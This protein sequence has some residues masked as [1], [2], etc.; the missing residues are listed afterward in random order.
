[1]HFSWYCL[2]HTCSRTHALTLKCTVCVC[3]CVRKHLKALRRCSHCSTHVS[4]PLTCH[5]LQSMKCEIKIHLW[6]DSGMHD[7]VCTSNSHTNISKTLP[8]L[9]LNERE[10]EKPQTVL[11]ETIFSINVELQDLR[12][13]KICEAYF[14]FP[15]KWHCEVPQ[16]YL[17]PGQWTLPV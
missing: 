6:L 12:T 7:V 15:F 11:A 8:Q 13:S 4:R 1:M 10:L 17:V 5:W 16:I 2:Q 3:A 9:V 14:S